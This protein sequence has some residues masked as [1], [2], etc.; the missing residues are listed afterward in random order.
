MKMMVRKLKLELDMKQSI[1]DAG[2]ALLDFRAE[3]ADAI[4]NFPS[5]VRHDPFDR[6]LLAQAHVERLT[7]LTADETLLGL[8]LPNVL[9]ARE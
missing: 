6:M 3:H 8:G 4:E 2:L 5:L 1:S 9:D 7:F